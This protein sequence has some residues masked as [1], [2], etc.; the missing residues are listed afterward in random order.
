LRSDRFMTWWIVG[1][2]VYIILMFFVWC[3]VRVPAMKERQMAEW[4]RTYP[5]E[6]RKAK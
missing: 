2:S 1:A 5:S 4:E 3:L 6:R